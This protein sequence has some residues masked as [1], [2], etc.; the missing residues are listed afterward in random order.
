MTETRAIR[1]KLNGMGHVLWINLDTETDRK[2][3]MEGLF[4]FYGIENTRISAIDARG[5]NDVSDLLVGKFPEL[6]TQGE[7]GCALSHLKAIKYFYYC[8]LY[9][10]PSPRDR[11]RSR[12]PSSA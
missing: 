4:N 12:M 8:L 1:K 10:S 6:V 7:L 3:H 9:T 11:T 2:D 5:D